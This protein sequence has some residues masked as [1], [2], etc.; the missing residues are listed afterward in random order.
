TSATAASIP[1][2]TTVPFLALN[3][4]LRVDI[5]DLLGVRDI[6]GPARSL[7][8]EQR[9]Q[10][11]ARGHA[12]TDQTARRGEQRLAGGAFH[13]HLDDQGSDQDEAGDHGGGERAPA[14]DQQALRQEPEHEHGDDHLADASAPT[15]DVDSAQH[16]AG[17]RGQEKGRAD[18]V[19]R[20]VAVGG[21]ND[22]GDS[23]HRTAER[24]D[25]DQHAPGA[26]P[27]VLGGG[28]VVPDK[29]QGPAESGVGHDR[30][31]DDRQHG[32]DQQ[33]DRYD[34]D[35]AGAESLERRAEVVRR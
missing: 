3:A 29:G 7:A 18:V 17:D 33:A 10:R 9:T 1:A 5:A 23:G 16:D 24:E 19:A 6:D 21:E 15:E 20:R 28:P 32:E 22:A 14:L 4:F 35:E 26:N 30:D 25:R 13:R 2:A 34:T 31:H 8:I 27:G 12:L 11:S